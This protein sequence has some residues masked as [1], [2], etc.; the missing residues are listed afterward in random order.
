[1]ENKQHL[2][3]INRY[4]LNTKKYEILYLLES[5]SRKIV[6]KSSVFPS[7]F[8]INVRLSTN[9]KFG[10]YQ[11]NDFLKYKNHNKFFQI[12]E[13]F[14][15][16][17]K[18]NILFKKGLFRANFKKPG[19]INFAINSKYLLFLIKIFVKKS[20]IKKVL[21]DNNQYLK[22]KIM[23]DFSSPNS[24]KKMHIGH[25]RSTVIGNSIMNMLKLLNKKVFSNN[26][27]GDWG[28]QFG[29]LIMMVKIYSYS[30]NKKKKNEIILEELEK[31]YQKG[32][33]LYDNNKKF[34]E[35]ANYELLK[36]QRGNKKSI[37][38]W[39][40][41][42]QVSLKNFNKIYKKMNIK[43]D[44]TRGESF[45]KNEIKNVIRKLKE[46]GIAIKDNG[47]L[48]IFNKE[49]NQSIQ[50][51][52]IIL[53]K[54][55]TVGYATIDLANILFNSKKMGINCF[56]YVTDD[57]QKDYFL[58][59]FLIVQKWFS[60][61]GYDIPN[62]KHISFGKIFKNKKEIFKTRKGRTIGL[63]NVIEKSIKISKKIIDIKHPFLS[64]KEKDKL[65]EIIGVESIKYFDLIQNRKSDYIFLWDQLLNKSGNTI[66]HIFYTISRIL[67]ILEKFYDLNKKN[68]LK[69]SKIKKNN[70][71]FD[72]KN[73]V[74]NNLKDKNEINLSQLIL[75]FTLKV[76]KAIKKFQ[77]HLIANHLFNIS[78]EFSKFYKSNKIIIIKNF[79]ETKRKILI[80]KKTLIVLKFG[81]K[82]LG[83]R[84][85][86]FM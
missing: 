68:K 30:F 19:F 11:I 15:K 72:K 12:T 44:Y 64:K 14:L 1:M 66:I 53:K 17:I 69:N 13:F 47:A 27:I 80:C 46:T 71:I 84:F 40:I 28:S 24:A 55:K 51:P 63:N 67:S 4:L 23:V 61:M 41:I 3:K 82:T 31:L 77:P 7:H 38:I 52:F 86:K 56:I 81:L 57:R 45:F 54:D 73:V 39:K 79:K 58:G 22:G 36:L 18:K 75:T 6:Q 8:H 37:R 78:R 21:K 62:M 29:I 5:I 16:E 34:K 65:S 43:F 33:K 25:L 60:K 74:N 76:K 26:Y 20:K 32:V 2:I 35:K 50:Y 9:F 83:I 85:P 42:N 49:N 48:V 70:L 10:I 59:L